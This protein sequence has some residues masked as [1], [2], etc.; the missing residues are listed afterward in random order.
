MLIVM[1]Q[2]VMAEGQAL[3]GTVHEIKRQGVKEWALELCSVQWQGD[4]RQAY[5]HSY[6]LMVEIADMPTIIAQCLRRGV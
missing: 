4:Q 3:F 2:C 6:V 5:V 1:G